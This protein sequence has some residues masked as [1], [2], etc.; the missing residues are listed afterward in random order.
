MSDLKARVL[1]PALTPFERLCTLMEILRSPQGCNWDRAQTH[2][3]L[4][5]YLVEEAYEVLEAVEA[6][7]FP[8]LKEE[9]G[10]LLL[11]VVFHAQMAAE[12]GQFTAKDV[13]DSIVTKLLNRHPHVFG[14]RRDLK[15]GEVRD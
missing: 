6:G 2:R 3:T 5:P 9:L 14:E 7:N 1:D 12:D 10:D 11:Q 13:I 15:P 8:A 4:L